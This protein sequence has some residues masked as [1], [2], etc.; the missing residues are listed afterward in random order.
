M[1]W[2]KQTVPSQIV[3][4]TSKWVGK[5]WSLIGDSITEFASNRST[6]NYYQYIS[7]SLGGM[8]ITNVARGGTG[9]FTMY[10]SSPTFSNRVGVTDIASDLIT[11]FGGTNDWANPS[12]PL[13]VMGDTD[14]SI[15][16]Y[17]A[18]YTTINSLITRFPTKTIAVFTPLPRNDGT[19][20]PWMANSQGYKLSDVADAVINVANHF[21]IP[22]LDLYRKSNM[23]PWNT[24]FET[25]LMP[26]GLHPNAAGHQILA[27]KILSFLNTL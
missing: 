21:S 2:T 3:S 7:D 9:Y 18:I 8:T 26:D 17:G 16:L 14:G 24:S 4:T 6:K 27:D 10:G 25:A 11:V 5:N 13:G 1:T 20:T 15:S 12:C 19:N 22:V 23:Y